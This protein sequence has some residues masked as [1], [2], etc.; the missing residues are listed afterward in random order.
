M[1]SDTEHRGAGHAHTHGDPGHAHTH[2]GPGHAHTHGGPGHAHTH[3]GP[4]H[5]H[6]HG[7]HDYAVPEL[8]ESVDIF[9]TILRDGSQQEGLSLTVD[10]KLRVAEQ[11]DHLGVTY[12]EGGWPG[13]NPK[14]VE[15]FAR[16]RT[17]LNLRTA[18]L[19]AFGSTRRAG[20][21]PEDDAVLA[22][23]IDAGA[24]VACIVAKSW[25]RHV[26]EAL[27]T[28][29]DEAVAMVADSVRFLRAHDLRV[30]LDA[31]HFFDGYRG[32][33]DFALRVLAAAEEA[34]ADALVL[35]DTNGGSLPDDVGRA[36]SEVRERTGA[37]LGIHCHNDAGCAVA[38]SLVA[39]QAGVTQ[40]QGCVNGYGE[41]AG[42]TD[43][44][45]AIPNLSLKLRIRTIP[46]DRLERLTPVAHHIAELVNIAPDPQQPYVGNSVF[47]HK[48]GLHASAVARSADLYQHVEPDL[49]G[50]GTRVV[51]SEMA[52]RSTLAMKADELGLDLDGEVIGRVLDELKRLEHE[53]YHFEVADGSLELLLR[54]ATGWVADFFTVESFRV[55][56]DHGPTAA[57]GP[58]Q[59]WGGRDHVPGFTTEATV[60]VHVAGERL[61]A[62]AEGNGPVNALDGALRAAIGP[63]FGVLEHIHLTDFRVRVLDSGRGTGSV[64]RVL[65]DTSDG[66]R[67]WT[68]IGVSEN[69]IEASW[70]A[71]YDSIVYGL[72]HAT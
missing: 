27:R 44:S 40:V 5:A 22:N 72:L 30:F 8:P 54:R 71:L 1:S 64:T 43:L 68:T 38:N 32:N 50:N 59:E 3:G 62:V 67:T 66:E 26:A 58:G 33:P 36:V 49:V 13:A 4:G 70:Q 63:K 61:V 35:C 6:T 42:N 52:G 31:E 17:E 29:L 19:V 37:Q 2:G 48:A 53:G 24:P 45:A 21:K 47:A 10:D 18:T 9:D 34:G 60:K 46:S 69:I 25:D 7:A 20:V 51:V 12:V 15:F 11:L 16:A 23:L 57:P 56:T 55:T 65:V 14:D 41:R 39:V 28:S